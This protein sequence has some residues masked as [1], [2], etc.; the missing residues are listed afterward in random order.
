[1]L[2]KINLLPT[3][4]KAIKQSN[5]R[6]ESLQLATK[7]VLGGFIAVVVGIF[8]WIFIVNQQIKVWNQRESQVLGQ[9]SELSTQE[10]S[11]R[12]FGLVLG[13]VKEVIATRK[14]FQIVL[15][16]IYGSI[17]TGTKLED[18]QFVDRGV[19]VQAKSA[20]V[21]EFVKTINNFSRRSREQSVF[22]DMVLSSVSRTANGEYAFDL[23]LEIKNKNG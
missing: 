17:P 11:Y 15:S 16:E 21:H 8:L 23:E 9:L 2:T 22:G 6:L 20:N 5:Q 12:R 7:V 18:V 14:D 1:M 19:L 13:V 4:A 3:S 10:Y